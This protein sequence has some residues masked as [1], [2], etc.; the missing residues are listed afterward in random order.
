MTRL[1]IAAA[2][3]AGLLLAGCERQQFVLERPD[4]TPFAAADGDCWDYAGVVA[5][6]DHPAMYAKCMARHGWATCGAQAAC[7]R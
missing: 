6:D 1:E 4:A 7:K 3:V 2:L 5:P